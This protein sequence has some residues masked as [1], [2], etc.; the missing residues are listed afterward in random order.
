ME[1]LGMSSAK[2]PQVRIPELLGNI[3]EVHKTVETVRKLTT[4]ICD[5]LRVGLN[6]CLKEASDPM[7]TPPLITERCMYLS[8]IRGNLCGISDR[9]QLILSTLREV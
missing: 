7:P 6:E 2:V 1:A 8:E 5:L 3:Q 4:E 9:L